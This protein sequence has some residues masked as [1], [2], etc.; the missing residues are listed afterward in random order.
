MPK[1]QISAALNLGDAIKRVRSQVKPGKN[2][3]VY[4]P[5]GGRIEEINYK[6]FLDRIARLGS[7]YISW[8]LQP[9]DRVLI[10]SRDDAALLTA[11]LA[12]LE[13]GFSAVVVDAEASTAEAGHMIEVASPAGAIVDEALT[14]LWP[15]SAVPKVLPVSGTGKKSGLLLRKLLGRRRDVKESQSSYPG[16]LGSLK[17]AA[18]AVDLDDDL[19]AYVIFTSGSTSRPKGVRIS[20]G[21]LLAH[22]KTLSNQ[23]NYDSESRLLDV[24]PLHHADGLMH[25]CLTAWFTAATVLRPLEFSVTAVQQLLDALYTHRATHFI[26]VPTML[27]IIEKYSAGYEDAFKTDDFRFVTS[28]AGRLDQKLW[29]RFQN[30]F[31]TRVANVY[32]LTETVTGG[33]FCG[34]DANTFCLG[35]IGKPVDCRVRIVDDQGRD[36]PAGQPGELLISGDNLFL[37]YLH[38]EQATAAVLKNGWLHTGDMAVSD[39][40]GFY[41]IVGRIKNIVITGGLNVQPE[42]VTDVLKGVAGVRDAV[43]FGVEDPTFGEILVACVVLDDGLAISSEQL[44]ANCREQLSSY[45]VPRRIARV[46]ALPMGPTGKVVLA[47]ARDLLVETGSHARPASSRD[48]SQS[49]FAVGA[50][51]FQLPVDQL[52][53]ESSPDNTPG[54]DSFAQLALVAEIENTF[55]IRFQVAEV[56]AIRTLGDALRVL[57]EKLAE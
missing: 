56:L 15:L 46:P 49:L 5:G 30:R 8:G 52:T 41:N 53:L 4:A 26:T 1:F 50:K 13:F 57:Q 43:A 16:I 55:D 38:D 47:Q 19:E 22:A 3:L 25:G 35:S 18:P 7:L 11:V 54:W 17:P 39:D 33:I 37:G 2:F 14:S 42:E 9:G 29:S 27:A 12:C 10:A 28:C 51:V 44:I 24:L 31:G 6:T 32:G 21:S 34:P 36:L 23:M 40:D 20:R 45:K 48:A